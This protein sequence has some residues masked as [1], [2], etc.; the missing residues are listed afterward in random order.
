MMGRA[1]GMQVNAVCTV[2]LAHNPGVG[3][4][5]SVSNCKLPGLHFPP[6]RDILVFRDI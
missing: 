5:Q 4:M 3:N 1:D 6:A 2:D